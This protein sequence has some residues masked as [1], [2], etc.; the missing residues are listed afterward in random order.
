MTQEQVA[1]L[2]VNDVQSRLNATRVAR[3]RAAHDG[4]RGAGRGPGGGRQR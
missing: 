4:G 1:G 3:D 2:M